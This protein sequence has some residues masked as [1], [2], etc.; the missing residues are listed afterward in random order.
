MGEYDRRHDD[1]VLNLVKL[2]LQRLTQRIDEVILPKLN[3]HDQCLFG[4]NRSNGMSGKLKDTE[5]EIE[6]LQKSFGQHLDN[7]KWWITT[8]IAVCMLIIG[9]LKVFKI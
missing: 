3:S 7:H 9:I 8:L 4:E 2:E 6:N 5:S 1:E